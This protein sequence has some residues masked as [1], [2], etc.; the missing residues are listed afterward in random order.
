MT[1]D[2]HGVYSKLGFKSLSNVDKWM[3]MRDK[4]PER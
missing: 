2:A 4:R 1:T 3:E